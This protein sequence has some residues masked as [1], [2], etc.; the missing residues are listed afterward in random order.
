MLG[1]WRLLL[2]LMVALTH[3]GV[4]IAG[5]D[6]GV[7]AVVCFYLI[8]GYVMTGLIRTH[9][10]GLPRA[11]H[12]YAD[13]FLRLWPHY[14]AVAGITLIWFWWT[15][16]R[17]YFLAHAPGA[18]DAFNNLTIVPLNYYMFNG[19]DRFALVPTGWSLGAEIQFYAIAPLAVLN[20]RVRGLVLVGSAAVFV[21]A[22]FGV[23]HPEWYG[24]R[25]PAG[26]LFMFMLGSML[27]DAH[28]AS[29]SSRAADRIVLWHMLSVALLAGA[30]AATHR[31]FWAFNVEVLSGLFLG[32]PLLHVLARLPRQGWDTR[33][34]DLAYGIFLNH[35]TVQLFLFTRMPV[36]PATT[37]LYIALTI[38]MA[39]V[40]FR[41]IEQPIVAMRYTL[42]AAKAK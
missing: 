14:L 29:G 26:V 18:I 11:R 28:A 32:L 6:M 10:A 5:R 36:T 8:S 40:L 35:M 20:A 37:V 21:L 34:G 9:Y 38:V 1:T 39:F 13:R 24:Y 27:Y 41:A 25:L 17:P 2:A 31:L 22:C 19:S 16:S 12:F 3:V 4:T 30:L 42:R 23:V 33:L 15:G 7:T